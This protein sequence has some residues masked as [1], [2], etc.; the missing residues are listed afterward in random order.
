MKIDAVSA[1]L[2]RLPPTVPWEDATHQVTGLE[3]IVV[4]IY[5]DCGL[6][7]TG[8]AYTTGIGGAAILS[9]LNEYIAG[10]L[11]GQNPLEVA[12]LWNFLNNQLHRTGTGGINTLALAAVDIALW[13]IVGQTNQIPLH[14]WFGATR[15]SIPAYASGIDLFMDEQALLETVAAS[16][17]K[18]FRTIKIKVGREDPAEDI[19]RVFAVRRL[20]GPQ[21]QLVVDANQKWTVAEA[22]PQ[23]LHLREAGLLWVEEP[24]HAEDIVGYADLRRMIGMPLALGES[25]YTLHQFRDYLAANAMDI[26]QADVCRTG[27]ITGWMSIAHLAAAYHR[28]LAPHYLPELSVGVLCGIQNGLMVEWVIGGSLTEMGVLQEPLRLENGIAYPFEAP[29]HGIRFDLEKLAPYEVDF[30]KM[31]Q[32]DLRSAK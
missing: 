20:I 9:L 24:L 13:D 3:Y 30:A 32:L 5:T 22:I 28:W 12:R 29:G 2:Y 25:L 18:G 11:I 26:V 14:R 17:E 21:R 23:L 1:R 19:A 6:T 10:M 27:G 15:A 8:F 4:W 31:R 7:G 16:L